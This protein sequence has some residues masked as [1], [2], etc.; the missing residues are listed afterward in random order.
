MSGSASIN[1]HLFDI[2]PPTVTGA[3]LTVGPVPHEEYPLPDIDSLYTG[4]AQTTAVVRP[5]YEIAV[6]YDPRKQDQSQT[7]RLVHIQHS[8]DIE[9]VVDGLLLTLVSWDLTRDGVP[10][11]ITEEE[12]ERIHPT[13][14]QAVI[15]AI[16]KDMFSPKNE[17]GSPTGSP[18]DSASPRRSTNSFVPAGSRGR[19]RG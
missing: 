3:P 6:E 5:G 4:T 10:V 13:I 7:A 1:K 17:T 16:Q 19:P 14:L 8:G 12:L 11:P 9:A 2:R 15:G 18:T